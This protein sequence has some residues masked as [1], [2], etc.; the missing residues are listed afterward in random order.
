MRKSS[1][2][3][4][5]LVASLAMAFTSGCRRTQAQN[6]VGADNRIVSDQFCDQADQQRRNNPNS[7][8]PYRWLFGGSSGGNL[9][10][11]VYGGSASPLPGATAIRSNGVTSGGF[12]SVLGGFGHASGAGE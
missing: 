2:I 12:G 1:Q 3:T 5:G 6:C 10:D 11:N 9:G 7:F 4:L 8:Y